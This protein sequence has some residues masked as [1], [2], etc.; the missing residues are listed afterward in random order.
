MRAPKV[1]TAAALSSGWCALSRPPNC[2]GT[3]SLKAIAVT[4]T[5]CHLVQ[6]L[7]NNSVDWTKAG[8]ASRQDLAFMSDTCN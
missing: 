7:L 6:L 2:S 5:Q 8:V 3:R 4:C 1:K